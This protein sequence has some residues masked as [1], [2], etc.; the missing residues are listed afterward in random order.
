M[1]SWI[2]AAPGSVLPVV[3]LCYRL[4]TAKGVLKHRE[5][6]SPLDL[7]SNLLGMGGVS[8]AYE[9]SVQAPRSKTEQRVAAVVASFSDVNLQFQRSVRLYFHGGSSKVQ[10]LHGY[11]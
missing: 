8:P 2:H 4:K 5:G 1:L 6:K 9:E 11:D 10:E 3:T 7:H